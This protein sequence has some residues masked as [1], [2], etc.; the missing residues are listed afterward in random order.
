MILERMLE[1][2]VDIWRGRA[3][4]PAALPAVPSGFDALDGELPG[5]GW[6]V[7][8]LSEILGGAPGALALTVPALARLSA[9]GRWV[10]L[11][12]PPYLPYAPGLAGSGVD[13][14]RLLLV[15]E[16]DRAAVLWAMEQGLRSGAC[17]AV[18]GWTEPGT[19]S[20]LRR[21]QLAA[22]SGGALAFLFRGEAAARRPSPA[23]LRLRAR[24]VWQ[25]L[26][27]WVLK[28]RGGLPAGPLRL[29]L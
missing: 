23:S 3:P 12:T 15:R 26:E 4:S 11:V 25:G 19:T 21:L 28:R 6:P 16:G 8:A 22:E 2:R 24:P 1:Q 18:L 13:L 9:A 27:V 17:G 20:V 7:G 29:A 10:L 5:G 14:D